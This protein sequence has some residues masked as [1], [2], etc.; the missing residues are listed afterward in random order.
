MKIIKRTM[1]DK[2]DVNGILFNAFDKFISLFSE[3]CADSGCESQMY[4]F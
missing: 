3:A 1:D 2:K 4:V